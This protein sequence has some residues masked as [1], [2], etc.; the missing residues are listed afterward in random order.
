[1]CLC[2]YYC[3]VL[4]L[5][6]Y[7]VF[8]YLLKVVLD[9]ITLEVGVAPSDG[10]VPGEHLEGGGL[11]CPVLTQQTEALLLRNAYAGVVHGHEV[12]VLLEEVHQQQ[13]IP[14]RQHRSRGGVDA[15][16]LRGHVI[17]L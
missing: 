2:V 1:M 3:S 6:V 12:A 9:V 11:A 13:G 8:D 10:H 17:V 4:L 16:S 15:S 14:L 7:F 5:I